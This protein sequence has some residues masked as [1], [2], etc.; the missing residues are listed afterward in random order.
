MYSSKSSSAKEKKPVGQII[1]IVYIIRVRGGWSMYTHYI[2]LK[3]TQRKLAPLSN[4]YTNSPTF[5]ALQ[6]ASADT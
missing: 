6:Q 2:R 4:I 5:P 1:L 3:V